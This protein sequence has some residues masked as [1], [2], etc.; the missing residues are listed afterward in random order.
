MVQKWPY[1]LDLGNNFAATRDDLEETIKQQR[2]QI[3]ELESEKDQLS[4]SLVQRQETI[5]DLQQ[6]VSIPSTAGGKQINTQNSFVDVKK[7]LQD[8]AKNISFD[9][10]RTS[11]K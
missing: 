7:N 4:S 9:I 1:F 6:E 11:K 5:I 10:I 2:N 3:K 8:T